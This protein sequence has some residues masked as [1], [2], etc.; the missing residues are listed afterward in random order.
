MPPPQTI[1]FDNWELHREV[2][3]L[4]RGD[5][6]IRLQDQPLQVLNELLEHPGELVTREQLIARLWPKGVVDFDTGI[7]SAVR[8]LRVALQDTGDTPRYIET[9][10]RKGYRFI[11]QIEAPDSNASPAA[12]I[13]PSHASP[14]AGP[15]VIAP[16]GNPRTRRY[17]LIYGVLGA[18]AVIAIAVWVSREP[19]ATDSIAATPAASTSQQERSLAVLPLQSASNAEADSLLGIS[20]A[21]LL[22]DRLA[23]F[24]ELMV[25]SNN[26][27]VNLGPLAVDVRA[28]GRK[29]K[30]RFALH[31]RIEQ[32]GEELRLELILSNTDTGAQLWAANFTRPVGDLPALREEIAARVARA[33]Q[34]PPG[35]PAAASPINLEAYQLYVQGQRL[36]SNMR[37]A[38]AERAAAMFARATVL[39]PGF[40]RAYLLSGQASVTAQRIQGSDTPEMIADVEKRYERALTLDPMLG[41]VWVERARLIRDPVRA[42]EFYKKGLAL[43]PSYGQGYLRYAELMFDQGRRGE[44]IELVERARRVDPLT[45]Q[46]HSRKA[47][48]LLVQR[49]DVAGHE[50]LLREALEINPSYQVAL[51]QL[52]DSKHMWSG[53]FAEAA[54]LIERAIAQDPD[55]EYARILAAAIYLDL[56]DVVAAEDV[57]RSLGQNSESSAMIAQYR[58]DRRRAAEIAY[59]HTDDGIWA[60]HCFSPLG[61]AIRDAAIASGDFSRAATVLESKYAIGAGP[62]MTRRGLAAVYADTL[63]RA[64]DVERSQRVARNFLALLEAEEV[65]RPKQ[66]FNRERAS[67]FAILG[68]DAKAIAVLEDGQRMNH[69]ARWWYTAELDP[70]FERV[71]TDPRFKALGDRAKQH[72]VRQRALLEAMREKGVVP[73]RS[74]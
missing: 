16:P 56:D 28:A 34:F 72:R 55:S 20:V 46:V 10:P 49:S 66:W 37:A 57:T 60:H 8:K 24:T 31:G 9:V 23:R 17:T 2:G 12:A 71:R 54:A 38:D 36:L 7:N 25:I 70:V 65:A 59:A 47:F 22:R 3:D 29:L 69:F 61:D 6:K 35:A 51:L 18:L 30:S 13:A 63:K 52:A 68:E 44:A 5:E 48:F 11:G 50:A 58:R 67:M 62:A 45:P 73:R 32:R 19:A 41:E 15:A 40:A 1:R 27:A 43:S 14:E 4:I 26:S 53:G 74:G 21:D 64:G 39:D 42:E 33:L